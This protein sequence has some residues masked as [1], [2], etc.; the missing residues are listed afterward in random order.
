[1]AQRLAEKLDMAQ[2]LAEKEFTTREQ[3][4][5][6]LEQ[7]SA[8][9]LAWLGT[10]TPALLDST[11]KTPFGPAPVVAITFPAYHLTGHV[12]QMDYMQTIYG[13]R[14]RHVGGED[15]AVEQTRQ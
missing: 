3:V 11:V 12:A 4:I 10:V 14:D 6:L 1:M 15:G 9:Y 5:S 8:E 7:T 13:D 2:R